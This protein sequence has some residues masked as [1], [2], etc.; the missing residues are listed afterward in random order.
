MISA[1]TILLSSCHC[2]HNIFPIPLYKSRVVIFLNSL[3][4]WVLLLHG[5]LVLGIKPLELCRSVVVYLLDLPKAVGK[6]PNLSEG[7]LQV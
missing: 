1:V 7:D 4:L 3:F 6:V 5:V 2:R